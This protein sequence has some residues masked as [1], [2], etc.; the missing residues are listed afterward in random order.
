MRFEWSKK[1]LGC[2]AL[3]YVLMIYLN[4]S[5]DLTNFSSRCMAFAASNTNIMLIGASITPKPKLWLSITN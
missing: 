1:G 4:L 2:I 5:A 3:N